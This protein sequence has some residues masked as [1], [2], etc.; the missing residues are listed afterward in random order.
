MLLRI[1]DYAKIDPRIKLKISS[2]C[3]AKTL[4]TEKNNHFRKTV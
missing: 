1:I 3:L 4:K 2:F